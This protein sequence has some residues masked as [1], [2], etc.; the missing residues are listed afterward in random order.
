MFAPYFSC[1]CALFHSFETRNRLHQ[2][3]HR[4][5]E[6]SPSRGRSDLPSSAMG[7]GA[8]PCSDVWRAC[9]RLEGAARLDP[10]LY[11]LG[12][13]YRVLRGSP[14]FEIDDCYSVDHLSVLAIFLGSTD[15]TKPQRSLILFAYGNLCS[16]VDVGADHLSMD[17]ITLC[18][19][20][21]NKHDGLLSPLSFL[22]LRRSWRGDPWP[23]THEL[24]WSVPVGSFVRERERM[25][26]EAYLHINI[27]TMTHP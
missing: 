26:C 12:G 9:L 14:Q 16:V 3:N 11:R 20:L 4:R 18:S 22:L 8:T 10:S 5:Q 7:G 13:G 17:W 19:S 15:S 25:P 24:A 1:P 27:D 23:N 6:R 2:T 21:W